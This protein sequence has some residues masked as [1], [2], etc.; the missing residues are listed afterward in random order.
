[1]DQGAVFE[2][3]AVRCGI[4]FVGRLENYCFAALMI[5]P[6]HDIGWIRFE[7]PANNPRRPR[8]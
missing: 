4:R 5:L 6:P 8:V 3:G 1:M 7:S 2:E